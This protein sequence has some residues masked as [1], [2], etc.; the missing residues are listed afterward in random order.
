MSL[1]SALDSP[2]TPLR[3]FLDCELSAG[4]RPLRESFHAQH[5]RPCQLRRPPG[6]GTE[7]GTVGTAVDQRLRLAFTAARPVDLATLIGVA[8]CADAAGR[9][10]GRRMRRIGRELVDRL[11]DT[12]HALRPDDRD[13]PMERAHEE[14][15]H[16]ARLLLAAAW[17]QVAARNLGGFTYTPLFLVASEDPASFT[18]ERLLALP[19]PDLVADLLA[20]FYY[21]A[22]GPLAGLRAAT[23]PARCI[24]DPPL[25]TENITADADLL[26]DG[27]LLDVKSTGRPGTSPRPPPTNSSAISSWTPT[28]STAWTAL[29]STS[30]APPPSYGGRSRRIST[31]SASAA[32]N[33]PS[34]GP[35]SHNSSPAA[36]STSS[37]GPAARRPACGD[38]WKT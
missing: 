13:L 2:R 12:V 23:P 5:A 28:T 29:V 32:A 38:S 9:T 36:K 10:A 14:E 27:L 35:Y 8:S 1:T 21:A 37:P 31:S 22:S 16:L 33:S 24:G 3:R 30:P 19:H 25:N 26:V 15:E 7:A 4:V 20:Q 6:V 17:Y 34:Y 18:L 11:T